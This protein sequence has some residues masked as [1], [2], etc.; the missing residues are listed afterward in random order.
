MRV[1]M[2]TAVL[3]AAMEASGQTSPGFTQ[4]TAASSPR[5]AAVRA[6][7]FVYVA[8]TSGDGAPLGGTDVRVQTRRTLESIA[9]TLQSAGSSLANAASVTVYL[10]DAGDF[11]AMN[12][13]YGAF[14]PRNPPARTTLIV[15]QPLARPGALVEMSVIAIPD[16][17]E[18]TVIHPTGWAPVP[19]PYSYG[20]KSG[21]TLFLAGLVSRRGEDNSNVAGDLEAQTRT[22]LDNGATILSQAGM[23]M[24][25]VVATRVFLARAADF[26]AMNPAYRKH[27]GQTPPARV[28]VQAR[29]PGADFLIEVSMIAVRT[30]DRAA[31]TPPNPDGTPGRPNPNLSSAIRV[32]N[33]LYS[34]AAVGNIP[35]ATDV[36]AQATVIVE[37]LERVLTAGGFSLA[38]V[39]DV[40]VYL[41]DIARAADVD[42]VYRSVFTGAPPPR[43]T[44]G[45]GTVNGELLE[46]VVVAAK[47]R[48]EQA[49][50]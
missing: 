47:E 44:V 11:A 18:R 46:V 20:I 12:E 49:G 7:G 6:G 32:A 41:A 4:G 29:L 23:T 9:G 45:I 2:T 15:T 39:V 42:E 26:P 13:V 22:V 35:S 5:P 21:P 31:V 33:T 16:G 19:G 17:A 10:R 14:F 48:G 34:S 1:L 50:R 40:T 24:D 8:G 27:F 43:T 25:D 38:D 28:T 37:R 36:R 30:S 3:L